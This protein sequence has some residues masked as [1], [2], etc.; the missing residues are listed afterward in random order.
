MKIAKNRKPARALRE[1]KKRPIRRVGVRPRRLTG[2]GVED[3]V[4]RRKIADSVRQYIEDQKISRPQ[5]EKM[6]KRS[7]STMNHFF[8]GDF[9][10]SLLTRIEHALD[11]QFS[12]SSSVAPVEWGGYNR[13]GTAKFAG[14]YLTLRSDFKNSAQ[15]CAYVTTID[16]GKIDQAHIFDGRLIQ[17]P[18]INGYGLIFREERRVDVKYTHRGQVWIPVGQFVYLVSAYGDGRLRAAIA[19]L[20]DNDGKMKG[21]QLSLFNPIGA[22][23][24][25][26]AA[27]IVFLRREKISKDELGFIPP[28]HALYDDYKRMV[29]E[30]L[31]DVVFALPGLSGQ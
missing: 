17:R 28:G 1:R 23:F 6:V 8:A 21:I 30:A 20:P 19:S 18:K 3:H 9:A 13:E 26:A 16:W 4:K 31:G 25:P 7:E 29:S 27:P 5:F 11:R 15:I 24:T 12:G 14:S 10:D 22:A 2:G